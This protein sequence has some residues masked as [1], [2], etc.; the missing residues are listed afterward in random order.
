M[1][2]QPSHITDN[3]RI[4]PFSL[5]LNRLLRGW[6]RLAQTGGTPLYIPMNALRLVLAIALLASAAAAFTYWQRAAELAAENSTLRAK[7]AEHGSQQSAA[8]AAEEKQRDYELSRLR[9]DAAE[10]H[11]LRGE[12]S[13]ARSGAKDLERLRAENMQLRADNQQL[14]TASQRPADAPPS[15]DPRPAATRDQF[16]REN[17]SFAGYTTPEAALVSSIWAMREG[18]PQ[19]YLQSLAPEEQA[20]IARAWQNKP[21]A[22][23]IA[24]HQSDVASITGLRVLERQ[25]VSPNEVL[26]NVYIEGVGRLEKVSMKLIGN[27]WKFGGY[28]RPPAKQ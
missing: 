26:M 6:L 22:D 28:I 25:S 15:A 4:G 1:F 8:V 3:W 16:P 7:L 20:R 10:V 14:R 11:K 24:K 17:W 23:I 2:Y 5:T 9:A 19:T 13:Q 18:N 12:I 21:E 27:E